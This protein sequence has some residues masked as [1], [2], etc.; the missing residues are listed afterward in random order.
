MMTR[1]TARASPR[2]GSQWPTN[3]RPVTD[4][5]TG[6]EKFERW[7]KQSFAACIFRR[8][9]AATPRPRR[10]NYAETSRGAAAAATWKFRG[11][12]SRRRR[13]PAAATW[14]NRWRRVAATPRPRRGNSVETW[15]TQVQA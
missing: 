9:V 12:A 15:L 5:H 13:G 14:I 2:C 11:D 6:L 7:V 1:K 10:G 4:L 3:G 8:Q